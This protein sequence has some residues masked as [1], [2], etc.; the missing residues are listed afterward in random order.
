MSFEDLP[1]VLLGLEAVLPQSGLW[2]ETGREFLGCGA[3]P[4]CGPLAPVTT[5][6]ATQVHLE[7][8]TIATSTEHVVLGQVHGH[9][10]DA[11]IKQDGQQQ[12][13]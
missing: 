11:H 12:V 1:C 8:G 3:E 9:R 13:S 6:P 4:L 5:Y 2:V 7:D 10:S